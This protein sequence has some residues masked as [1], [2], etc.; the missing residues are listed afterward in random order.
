MT[1]KLSDGYNGPLIHDQGLF[2]GLEAIMVVIAA[3]CLNLAPPGSMFADMTEA[4]SVG[5]FTET[6]NGGNIATRRSSKT[7]GFDHCAL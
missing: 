1:N 2:L 4:E 6:A 5:Y 7:D 3:F